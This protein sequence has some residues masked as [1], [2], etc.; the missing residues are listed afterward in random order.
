MNKRI[1]QLLDEKAKEIESKYSQPRP[2]NPQFEK[3]F[4]RKI[5]ILSE[6]SAALLFKKSSGKFA[7]T[8]CY[9]VSI[10]KRKDDINPNGY[11]QYFFPKDSHMRGMEQL[12]GL[13]SM[14]EEKNFPKNLPEG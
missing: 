6:Y 4:L 10:G 1:A 3:F 7:L 8:F 13:L 12:P 5:K 14:V 9:W 11:W 2:N